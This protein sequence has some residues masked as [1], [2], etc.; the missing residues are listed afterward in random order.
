MKTPLEKELYRKA[1]GTRLMGDDDYFSERK[2]YT[3]KPLRTK[4]AD[5]LDTGG[6]EGLTRIVLKEYEVAFDTGHEEV[7]IRK[8]DDIFA[9]AADSPVKRDPIPTSGR[10]VR[11]A[12]DFYFG[13]S[14]KPRTVQVR[15]PNTLKLGRHCDAHLVYRWLSA[16]EFRAVVDDGE[17]AEGKRG[18]K[19]MVGGRVISE[20]GRRAAVIGNQ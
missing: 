14:K 6:I 12:F 10:L 4:G 7:L 17:D 8:A 20:A 9:A 3:L 13:T 15:T 1:F 5:A 18:W 2:A 11:A 19:L 16:Q